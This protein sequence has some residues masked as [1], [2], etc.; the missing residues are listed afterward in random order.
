MRLRRDSFSILRE[1]LRWRVAMVLSGLVMLLMIALGILNTRLGYAD[2][3][4][5]SWAVLGAVSGCV[6]A[7]LTLPRGLGG[8]VF[9][10]VVA[11][12]LTL[13]IGFGGY[14]GR[15]MHHWAY[16]L[17]PVLV[18]LL[19]PGLAL[20]GMLLF[21]VFAT[22][23]TALLLPMIEVVRFTSG[24]GLLVCFMYTYALLESRA[25]AMLRF[26]SNHD[27]LSNCLNRR[28]FNEAVAAIESESRACCFLLLDIDHFK[29]INDSRGHLVGDRVITEV[30][31]VLGRTL[32]SGT[33][34]F[35]YGGEEFAVI[36]ADADEG[37]GAAL[38]ER[39]RAG[40]ETTDL[41][42]VH[43]TISIGVAAWSAGVGSPTEALARADGAL[44]SAKRAG[45]NRVACAGSQSN[46]PA[47]S[48]KVA[49]LR[50]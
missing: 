49:Q 39:M 33:D 36:L 43:V 45:R 34:L 8:A 13:V 46:R 24:Y 22:A 30:A 3:A 31:A 17:P 50:R 26:H 4:F 11:V 15:S 6:I 32:G 19:R 18:F 21:G 16:I 47:L 20:T 42:G 7:L 29:A 40:I 10:G 38:A 27:A 25:G 1:T 44:Y 23:I 41:H 9:F 14:S 48:N 35:R 2:T 28:T 12:A 5:L 37:T